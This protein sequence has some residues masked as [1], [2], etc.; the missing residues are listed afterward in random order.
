LNP[1]QWLDEYE[2]RLADLKQKSADLQENFAASNATVSSKD[3]SVTITIGPNGGLLNLQLGHR[4]VELG[5]A[6]LTAL[7]MET[8]K[9]AQRQAA[10]KVLEVFEPLGEGTEAMSMVM[11]S[12]PADETDEVEDDIDEVEEPVAP[13]AAPAYRADPAPVRPPTRARPAVDEDDDENRPW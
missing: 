13:P 9:I 4:A 5:A 3:G 12:I 6:R 1:Q 8:A 10:Q 11:D 2:A 7:I